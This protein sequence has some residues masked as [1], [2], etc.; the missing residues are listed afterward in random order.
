M[1]LGS[2]VDADEK[3]LLY[4][5]ASTLILPIVIL[6][7]VVLHTKFSEKFEKNQIF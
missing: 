7:K 4:R 5:C 3:I 2:V 1:W 6:V